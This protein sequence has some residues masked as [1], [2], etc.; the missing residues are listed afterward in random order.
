VRA[1]KACARMGDPHTTA[2]YR[3]QHDGRD[4][5]HI[6]L[7]DGRQSAICTGSAVRAELVHLLHRSF[8]SASQGQHYAMPCPQLQHRAVSPKQF[9]E[10]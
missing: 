2:L 6:V 1:I 4:G 3:S 7:H 10:T 5:H 8:S 9:L